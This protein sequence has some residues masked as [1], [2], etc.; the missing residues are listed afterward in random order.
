MDRRGYGAPEGPDADKVLYEVEDTAAD[1]G[2][3][4]DLAGL[5]PPR[6]SHGRTQS[7]RVDLRRRAPRPPSRGHSPELVRRFRLEEP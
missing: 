3:A 1:C 2:A 7:L 5:P 6:R 4:T